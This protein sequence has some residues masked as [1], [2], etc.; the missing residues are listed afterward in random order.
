[1]IRILIVLK[2]STRYL[3][4]FVTIG[5]SSES[6]YK[7]YLKIEGLVYFPYGGN[8]HVEDD[9]AGGQKPSHAQP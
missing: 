4:K 7:L 8:L 3:K 9:E 2:H 1:M 5:L 6:G